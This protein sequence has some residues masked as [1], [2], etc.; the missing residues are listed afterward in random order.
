[1][2]L[3]YSLSHT[4]THTLAQKLSKVGVTVVTCASWGKTWPRW[5]FPTLSCDCKERDSFRDLRYSKNQNMSFRNRLMK[6]QV[7]FTLAPKVL[8]WSKLDGWFDRVATLY[9][10]SPI[11]SNLNLTQTLDE[12]FVT[13][14]STQDSIKSAHWRVFSRYLRK[15]HRNLTS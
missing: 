3:V 10:K 7:E 14:E 4:H 15:L 2:D 12:T 13:F 6:R 11:N 9:K 8:I 5:N 1:M